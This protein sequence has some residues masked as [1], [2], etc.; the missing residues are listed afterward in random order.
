MKIREY[1]DKLTALNVK[2]SELERAISVVTGPHTMAILQREIEHA[3]TDVMAIEN[4]EVDARPQVIRVTAEPVP[5]LEA[6]ATHKL[7]A[8]YLLSNGQL[9]TLGEEDKAQVVFIDLDKSFDNTGFITNV[10]AK[11]YTGAYD[12][13]LTVTRT[14]NGFD[15]FDDNGTQGLQI[16][17][18]AGTFML[19]DTYGKS[20]GVTFTEQGTV[21]GDDFRVLIIRTKERLSFDIMDEGIATIEGLTITAVGEGTTEL[22]ISG[23][24]DVVTLPITVTV[25]PVVE[26]EPETPEVTDPPVEEPEAPTEPPTEPEAP[27]EEPTV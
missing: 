16:T 25:P 9:Q 12:M 19:V 27:T 3:A 6:G 1:L 24:Y 22:L 18:N 14:A 15:V 23:D 8:N 7:E 13:S 26:P 20:L 10:D 2:Q 4:L 5:S 21:A 11:G 17:E